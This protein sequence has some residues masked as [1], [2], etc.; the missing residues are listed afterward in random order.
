MRFFVT[1]RTG[2]RVKNDLYKSLTIPEINKDHTPMI[3]PSVHP[4][5]EDYFKTNI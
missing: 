5:H 2:I 1:I 3:S 4:S